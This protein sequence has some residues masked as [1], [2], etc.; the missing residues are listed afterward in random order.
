M[1]ELFHIPVFTKPEEPSQV[2]GTKVGDKV[3]WN[4]IGP[5]TVNRITEDGHIYAHCLTMQICVSDAS[6]FDKVP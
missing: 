3:M 2:L 5:L 1:M 4:G 6:R